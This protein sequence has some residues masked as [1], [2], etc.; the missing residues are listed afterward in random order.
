MK[1]N[2][3]AQVAAF[4]TPEV[5]SYVSAYLLARAYAETVR[6]QVDAIALEILTECPILDSETGEPLTQ[7]KQ[8]YRSTDEA[9]CADFYAEANIRE[10]HAGIKPPEMPNEHCPALVAENLVIQLSRCLIEASGRPLGVTPDKLLCAGDGLATWKRWI[11]LVVGLI[12]SLPDFKNPL[13]GEKLP[14]PPVSPRPDLCEGRTIWN[15]D[16]TDGPCLICSPA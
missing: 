11:D 3:P 16:G 8:L 12:V 4:A 14:P 15:S 6:A 9:A 2:I 5:K 10:R 13:T 7:S 1:S